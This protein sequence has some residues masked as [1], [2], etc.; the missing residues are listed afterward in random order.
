MKSNKGYFH[1]KIYILKTNCRYN[2]KVKQSQ[3]AKYKI[4]YNLI[5]ALK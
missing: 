4:R 5:G 1:S 2:V 3:K